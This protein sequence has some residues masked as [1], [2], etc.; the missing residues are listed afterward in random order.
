MIYVHVPFCKSFCRYC[1][2]YS[3]LTCGKPEEYDAYIDEIC[4]EARLRSGEIKESEYQLKT[5]EL[6]LYKFRTHYKVPHLVDS[7]NLLL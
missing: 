4:A 6:Q 1:D 3:E 7:N 5:L 2:F